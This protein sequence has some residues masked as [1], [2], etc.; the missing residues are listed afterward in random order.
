MIPAAAVETGSYSVVRRIATA[1][2]SEYEHLPNSVFNLAES[3][4][5]ALYTFRTA[6]QCRGSLVAE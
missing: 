4:L 2:E 6:N 1:S 3:V 5:Y